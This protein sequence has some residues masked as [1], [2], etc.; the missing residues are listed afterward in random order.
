MAETLWE[1]WCRGEAG[2]PD[3]LAQADA[4]TTAQLAE[5]LAADRAV[6]WQQGD[7]APAEEYL[8]QY[9]ALRTDVDALC[10]LVYGEFLLRARLGESPDLQEYLQRFPAHADALRDLDAS[11]QLN[12]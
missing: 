3:L 10:E 12:E 5:V 7:R 6:R 11:D 4:L 8:E 2:V 1:R 9:P